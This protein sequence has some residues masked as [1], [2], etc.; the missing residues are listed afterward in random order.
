MQLEK[1]KYIKQII[2]IKLTDRKQLICGY[3]VDYNEKWILMKNS[4]VDYVIDGYVIVRNENIERID[5]D[6]EEKWKEKVIKLKGLAPSDKDLILISN[7][8]TILQYLTDC[9]GVFELETEEE[10]VCYLGRLNSI[11]GKNFAID[12]LDTQGNWVGQ[13]TFT[14][15]EIRVIRFDTDYSNSL[16][17]VSEI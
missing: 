2:S 3:V 7:L 14:F 4:P 10:D 16:K 6:T 13:M 15:A 9:F 12:D 11:N 17:L 1:K 5:R 8:E